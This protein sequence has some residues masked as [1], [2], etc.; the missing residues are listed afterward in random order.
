M[1]QLLD[2]NAGGY[3]QIPG[4]AWKELKLFRPDHL[5]IFQKA[6]PWLDFGG[7]TVGLYQLALNR[8]K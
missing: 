8:K 6:N 5:E 2:K 1:T 7:L 4:D 3:G